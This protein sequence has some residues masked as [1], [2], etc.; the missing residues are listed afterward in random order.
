MYGIDIDKNNIKE[1]KDRMY[2][3]I[4]LCSNHIEN[5]VVMKIIKKILDTNIVVGDTLKDEKV[6]LFNSGKKITFINF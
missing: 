2:N 5:K 3:I 1:A 6:D 4:K